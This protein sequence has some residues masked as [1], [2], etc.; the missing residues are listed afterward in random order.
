M[1][2][3]FQDMVASFGN[4]HYKGSIKQQWEYTE[5]AILTIF[6]KLSMLMKNL[7]N[8]TIQLITQILKQT[9]KINISD[10]KKM[11]ILDG[12]LAADNKLNKNI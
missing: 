8:H 12:W 4:N 2:H 10:K 6:H 9:P 1:Q 5:L 7:V 11:M 3:A